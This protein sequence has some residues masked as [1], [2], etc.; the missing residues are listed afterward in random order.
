LDDNIHACTHRLLFC[1]GILHG[2]SNEW[3][4]LV[5][6]ASI[7]GLNILTASILTA[8]TSTSTISTYIQ[9]VGLFQSWLHGAF[10]VGSPA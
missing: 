4:T 10:G 9:I 7:Q 3:A 5:D 8:S 2:V 1:R 6:I